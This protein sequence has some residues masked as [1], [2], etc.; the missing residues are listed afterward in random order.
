MAVIWRRPL[1]SGSVRT[2][3]H[4]KVDDVGQMDYAEQIILNT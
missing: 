1:R 4:A 2:G 3:G